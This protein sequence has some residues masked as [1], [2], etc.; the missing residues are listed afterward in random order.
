M[1]QTVW[2]AVLI[3]QNKTKKAIT[4]VAITVGVLIGG[5]SYHEYKVISEQNQTLSKENE[6]LTDKVHSQGNAIFEQNNIL[7]KNDQYISELESSKKQLQNDKAKLEEEKAKVKSELSKQNKT[8]K[9]LEK[10]V[11]TLEAAEVSPTVT[12]T[13]SKKIPQ[14]KV[15]TSNVSLGTYTVTAYTNGNESTGKSPGHPAY[16]ITASGKKTAE[17]RTIACPKNMEFGTKLHI[18]GVGVREC[19]DT[20][21][22]IVG[23]SLD[24]FI[25]DLDRAQEFGRQ[26]LEVKQVN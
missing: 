23:K 6:K 10:R 4:G 9:K 7:M 11:Q 20:G 21:S 14:D 17:G 15:K 12:K 8:V 24:L 22:A 16:G 5:F 19:M 25:S 1:N 3:M 13:V 2:Q 18:E 26:R